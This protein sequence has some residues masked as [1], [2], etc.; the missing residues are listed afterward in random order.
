MGDPERVPQTPPVALAVACFQRRPNS[1]L[2]S[3][4]D[5]ETALAVADGV[6]PKL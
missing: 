2:R 3:A 4:S 1:T 6:A 5:G